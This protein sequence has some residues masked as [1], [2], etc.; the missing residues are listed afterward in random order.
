MVTV[1]RPDRT[2]QAPAV[3]VVDV[4]GHQPYGHAWLADDERNQRLHVRHLVSRSSD[5]AGTTGESVVAG[6]AQT[7]AEPAVIDVR[8]CDPHN[9]AGSTASA[10][11]RHPD[12]AREGARIEACDDL[13]TGAGLHRLG[14]PERS[15]GLMNRAPAEARG[16]RCPDHAG[17]PQRRELTVTTTVSLRR[18]A[19]ASHNTPVEYVSMTPVAALLAEFMVSGHATTAEGRSPPTWLASRCSNSTGRP[20][21]AWT[22]STS[23]HA[24]LAGDPTTLTVHPDSTSAA[25]TSGARA[26]RGAPS[27]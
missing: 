27:E 21:T 1:L 6:A 23:S 12:D 19:R 3:A 13:L 7:T 8:E 17:W 15:R 24:P 22:A 18:I 11:S 9:C 10:W 16:A 4:L 5:V 2:G 14:I 26:A 25:A 20:T